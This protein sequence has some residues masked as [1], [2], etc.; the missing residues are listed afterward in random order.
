MPEPVADNQFRLYTAFSVAGLATTGGTFCTISLSPGTG[1]SIFVTPFH[2][3]AIF[4]F[5][6][7]PFRRVLTCGTPHRN[8]NTDN[9]IHGT[10]ARVTAARSCFSTCIEPTPGAAGP[11]CWLPLSA[12]VFQ[13]VFGFQT[14]RNRVRQAMAMMAAPTS[15]SHGP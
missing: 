13:M 11:S 12:V 14:C 4:A 6:S 2:A 7:P 5:A 3:Y 15:T 8:T 1:I 10:Q 9:T